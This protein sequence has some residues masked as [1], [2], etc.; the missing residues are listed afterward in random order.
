MLHRVQRMLAFAVALT[1][2]VSAVALA[3]PLKGKTY[4]GAAP[5][6]GTSSRRHR[7]L[8]LHAGGNII[9]RVS[10]NGSTVTV[11]F[12][13]GHPVLYC[14]TPKLLRV[15]STSPARISSSGTFRASIAQRFQTGPGLAPITQVISGRFRGG[16]VSGTIQTVQAECG[17]IAHFSA[18]G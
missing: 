16:Y 10:H 15:Q 18:R 5:S 17:G 3:G 6:A 11:S 13:S 1:L 4:T 9:L 2:A 8:P 12:S 7:V 14:N